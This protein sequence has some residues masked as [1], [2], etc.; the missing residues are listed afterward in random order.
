[1]RI[2]VKL[3]AMLQDR[4]P[5]GSVGHT[6]EIEIPSGA[7]ARRVIEQMRIPAPMAHLVMVN[8]A[9]LTQAEI[10]QRILQEGE[11]LS[12]FPPIAGGRAVVAPP[13]RVRKEMGFSRAEFLRILPRFAAGLET[14]VSGN[15]IALSD[16][17]RRVQIILGKEQERA[18]GPIFRLPYTEVEIVLTGYGQAERESFLA[19]FDRH[20]FKGGG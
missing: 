2:K 11:T 3:F 10:D 7:T 17:K 19:R 20:F 16:G 13:F 4:L 9:H 12:I 8:G 14:Q 5:P 6:T 1:M 15:R 18:L